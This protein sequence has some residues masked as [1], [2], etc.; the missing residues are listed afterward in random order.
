MDIGQQANSYTAIDNEIT[1]RYF[2]VNRTVPPSLYNRSAVNQS[3]VRDMKKTRISSKLKYAKAN[4]KEAKSVIPL[5]I[6]YNDKG[7]MKMTKRIILKQ[8][9][10]QSVSN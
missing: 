3:L 9:K 10:T 1:I 6:S 2:K 5:T 4:E 7:V 8:I